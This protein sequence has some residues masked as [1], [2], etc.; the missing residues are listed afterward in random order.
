MCRQHGQEKAF[1]DWDLDA[2]GGWGFA[3]RVAALIRVMKPTSSVF[4]KDLKDY[5]HR[6]NVGGIGFLGSLP[7]VWTSRG[8]G[9]GLLNSFFFG[10]PNGFSMLFFS[11]SE[12]ADRS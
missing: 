6:K 8:Q 12:A 5:S 4:A 11:I 10:G 3:Y 9:L 2:L 7:E 1:I